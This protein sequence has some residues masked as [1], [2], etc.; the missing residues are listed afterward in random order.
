MPI[1]VNPA[2]RFFRAEHRMSADRNARW[3]EEELARIEQNK[4]YGFMKIDEPKT[5]YH[6]P[7]GEEQLSEHEDVPEFELE[8]GGNVS[9]AC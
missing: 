7:E 1:T 2:M 8:N 9:G 4:D 5:P 6:A 3:N